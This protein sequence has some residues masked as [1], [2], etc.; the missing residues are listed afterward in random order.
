MNDLLSLSGLF[1]SAV[2]S[3]TIL[4]GTSEAVLAGLLYQGLIPITLLWLVASLGNSMG[5]IINW[6]AGTQLEHLKDRRWFPIK[7]E[8]LARASSWFESYG[9]LSLLLAWVPVVG[10]ALTVVAGLFRMHLVPF[11]VLVF[12]GKAARYAAF[13]WLTQQALAAAGSN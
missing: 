6:W 13:I 3:A 5:C 2:G 10:D 11:F 12:I 4:P 7:E 1:F 8:Q 9:K